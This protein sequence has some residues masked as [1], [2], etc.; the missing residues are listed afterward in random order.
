MRAGSG[1]G[2]RRVPP[3]RFCAFCGA[4][5]PAWSGPL[6]RY[7]DHVCREFAYQARKKMW[8]RYGGYRRASRNR[9]GTPL[10]DVA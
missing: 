2:L 3:V 7:C 5:L 6:Q 9:N 4:D 1:K 10:G 8:I